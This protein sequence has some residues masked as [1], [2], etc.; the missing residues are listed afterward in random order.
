[1]IGIPTKKTPEVFGVTLLLAV[2]LAAGCGRDA[3][4]R[5]YPLK[6]QVL[7]IHADRQQITIRHDDIP[8]LMPGMTM[9]FP[10]AT[11]ELL[12][13]R[14]AGE[15]VSAELAVS[16]SEGTLVEITRVGMAPVPAGANEVALASGV[17]GLGD[18]L[19]DV[20]L[21]DQTD[22]RR[23]LS[24]WRGSPVLITF[25]FTRCPLP[26]F[27]PLD[28]PELRDHPAQRR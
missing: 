20:A 6:G 22:R 13:G 14:E 12:A 5:R 4:P 7:A 11:K 3:P 17:L 28:G 26:T 27:C 15:L 9:T 24:D 8:G 19:P 2:S 21:I 23:S 18:A 16:E 1:M 25:I 10:V